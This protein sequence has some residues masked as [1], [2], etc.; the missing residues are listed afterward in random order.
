MRLVE[1][2]Q[3]I[4]DVVR[5]SGNM[6]V[7]IRGLS[8]DSRSVAPGSLFFALRGA[9]VDGH[10]FLHQ[11]VQAGA[12]ALVVEDDAAVPPGVPFVTVRNARLAMSL[13]A[14]AFFE[15]PTDGVP[16]VGITG[17]N[18]KTTTTY[19]IEAML[20]KSGI[21]TAVLGTIN[22]RFRGTTLPAPNTT[23]ESVD[24]QKIL[25][26]LVDLGARGV[27]MEVSS[28]ALEQ[29]RVDGCRFDVGIFTNLTRDHLDYHHDMDSYRI[30]KQRFFS[31]L[32]APDSVKPV[33]S[34]V[35][36]IDDPAGSQFT[37]AAACPVISYGVSAEARVAARDVIF[38]TDGI[39][40]TLCTPSGEIDFTSKLLGRFN[41]YNILAAS[42]AS[43]AL[44]VPLQAIRAGIS[45]HGKVEGRLERVDN[46]RGVTLLVDYAHTGDALENVLSTLSELEHGRIVTVF[47]C[48]G[49]RDR[50]K[51]PIMGAIAGRYSDLAIITSDN[52]R[53]EGP[54]SIIAEIR[55]GILPLGIRE[56]TPS[57]LTGGIA[58]RG[59]LCV[60]SRREAIRLAV[61][62]SEPDDIVLIAG[63]GHEDYQIIGTEK[64]HF[65]DREEA[66]RAFREEGA[67]R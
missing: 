25:R 44:G 47:G 28:H 17:T 24:L 48:G 45:E 6:E 16:L 15:N 67:V 33:R 31:D 7:E 30:S 37:A 64:H 36:N 56:Y 49:D 38:S 66:A 11:A 43:F 23:P 14:A 41:L 29:R 3:T 4:G 35:V 5:N 2:L 40:G 42:A 61:R 54:E 52:P 20:E 62:L 27:V 18:G 8:Y 51:R 9:A 13:M 58:E 1:L 12:A 10:L 19:L 53:T 21:P 63:K 26:Q 57:D 59:F 46:D 65:D 22:Y 39:S 32:L 50:G 34:A 55:A 60:E